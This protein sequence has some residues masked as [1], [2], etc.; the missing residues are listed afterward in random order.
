MDATRYRK[1]RKHWGEPPAV[2]SPTQRNDIIFCSIFSPVVSPAQA[3]P[4]KTNISPGSN[5]QKMKGG[6]A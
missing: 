6:C 1:N 2:V 4:T 5:T 3:K